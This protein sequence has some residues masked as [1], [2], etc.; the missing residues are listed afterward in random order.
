MEDY[1]L[2]SE[3]YSDMYQEYNEGKSEDHNLYEI[4]NSNESYDSDIIE[5][6]NSENSLIEKQEEISNDDS[7][8]NL[9][10]LLGTDKTPKKT[11]KEKIEFLNE[12]FNNINNFFNDRLF[13]DTFIRCIIKDDEKTFFNNCD[14]IPLIKI[15][16]KTILFYDEKGRGKY[17]FIEEILKLIFENKIFIKD[18]RTNNIKINAYIC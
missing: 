18:C 2:G 13:K 1:E 9:G 15:E 8:C 3:N 4:N 17:Y 6:E 7:L 5:E 11:V 14:D 10:E 16:K 12:L